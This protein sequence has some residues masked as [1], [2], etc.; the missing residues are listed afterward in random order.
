MGVSDRKLR[1]RQARRDTILVAAA[2]VF[3]AH[4]F[5]EATIE[6]VAREAEIAVGTIYLY[7]CSRD[8]LYLSLIARRL[9]HLR[10]AYTAVAARK[11]SPLEELRAMVA[12]YL[13]YLG[14][15]RG[16]F[17]TQLS[18]SFSQIREELKRKEEI[19]IYDRVIELARE[20]F[21]LWEN[22]VKRAC[23]A[24]LLPIHLSPTQ[25]SVILWASLNG[26]FLLTGDENLFRQMTGMSADGFS[27]QVLDFHLNIGNAQQSRNPGEG[28]QRARQ[29]L[30]QK[31]KKD[32]EPVA[33]PPS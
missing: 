11:L 21:R 28:E 16:L 27:N 17:M 7:F 14:E 3:A 4:G 6:T 32:R 24:G 25:A 1:E 2:K 8:H 33:S 31:I 23:D 22:S 12:A 30:R 18:V 10:D 29:K 13:S 20:L 26:A 19:D 15:S 9:E 5:E